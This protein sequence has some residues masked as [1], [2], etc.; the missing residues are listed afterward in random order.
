MKKKD[1]YSSPAPIDPYVTT[2]RKAAESAAE[3]TICVNVTCKLRR[4]GCYG[5]EGC[6]GF[7][8]K[9]EKAR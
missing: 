8:P 7:K 3:R 5:A 1:R 6:F 9:P 4:A 2:H